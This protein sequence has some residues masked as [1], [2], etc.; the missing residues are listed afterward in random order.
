[1]RN[2]QPGTRVIPLEAAEERL[3]ATRVRDIAAS[4]VLSLSVYEAAANTS[5]STSSGTLI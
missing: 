2:K 5:V 1:M 4:C 3:P